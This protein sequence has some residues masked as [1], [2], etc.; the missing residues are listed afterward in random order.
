M[1]RLP[2][3]KARNSSR[4]GSFGTGRGMTEVSGPAHA[5]GQNLN[6]PHNTQQG[7]TALNAG[8]LKPG[9]EVHHNGGQAS[10]RSGNAGQPPR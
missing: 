10:I 5:G 1:A 7:G 4:S 6:K 2:E 8:R 3:N 9:R